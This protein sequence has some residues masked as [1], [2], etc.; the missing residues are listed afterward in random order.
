MGGARPAPAPPAPRKSGLAFF[1]VLL[2]LYGAV[3]TGAQAASPILGLLWSQAFALLLPA[4]IA[5]SGSNLR[6]ARALLLARRPALPAITLAPL[7]GAVAFLAAGALMQ[8]TSLLL[9]ARWLEIYDIAKL[10]DRPPLERAAL[11]V[12]AGAVAPF[13]EEVAFR[14]WLLT[15]LRTRYPT[16]AALALSGLLFAIMHLDPVRFSALVALGILYAWLTWRSGSVWPAILAHAT[17]NALGLVLARVGG[18][19]TSLRALPRAP[20]VA[21][22]ALLTLALSCVVLRFLGLAYR[23]ATPTPPPVEDALA[24]GDAA[25]PSTSFRL[26]RLPA[27]LVAAIT[28]AV[29]SLAALSLLAAARHR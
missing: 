9:P 8:L 28:A 5:A 21:S 14:G 25:D 16:G 11:S 19:A 24:R 3:G 10:F 17:N 27:R 20:E 2:G 15:A 12:A 23:R 1:G 22:G 29:L 6:P 4:F 13:C 7:V 18:A 26:G